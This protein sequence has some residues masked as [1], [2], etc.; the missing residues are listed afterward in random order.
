MKQ[1][2]IPARMCVSCGEMRPKKELI[3]VVRTPDGATVIDSGGKISGRGAYLCKKAGCVTQAKKRR[4]L[5]RNLGI[6]DCET[7]FSSLFEL[8]GE[9]G[10]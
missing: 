3:R 2:K 4:T 5:E 7:L 10:Q 9:N 6:N 8:C 1:K